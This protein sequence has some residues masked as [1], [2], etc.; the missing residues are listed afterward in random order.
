[1][2]TSQGQKWWV[3]IGKFSTVVLLL[4]GLFKLYSEVRPSGPEVVARVSYASFDISPDLIQA[5]QSFRAANSLGEI[6]KVVRPPLQ[7]KHAD[8]PLFEM[9]VARAIME[10]LDGAWP[11]Q[12]KFRIDLYKS[13]ITVSLSNNG[14]RIAEAVVLDLPASG[15]GLY[16]MEDGKR[17]MITVERAVAIGSIRPGN[18]VSVALWST[19]PFDSTDAV[20]VRVTHSV[21][22]GSVSFPTVAYGVPGFVA[23]NFWLLIIESP[24]VLLA[25]F[26][27]TLVI[28]GL[29]N[30]DEKAAA[31]KGEN[32]ENDNPPRQEGGGDG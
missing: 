5:F 26:I 16:T 2:Q 1:M 32:T 11:E 12:F 27:I 22:I 14:N 29:L 3:I 25:L 18:S 23:R 4:G 19:L 9:E 31:S 15:V 8:D 20:G 6:A 30:K 21:G 24:L 10:H 17:K 13:L 7:A 28:R